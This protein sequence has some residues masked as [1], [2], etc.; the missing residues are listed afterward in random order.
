MGAFMIHHSEEMMVSQHLGR[1][2]W[3]RMRE[4]VLGQRESAVLLLSPALPPNPLETTGPESVTPWSPSSHP[5]GLPRVTAA[6]RTGWGDSSPVILKMDSDDG[7]HHGECAG[8]PCQGQRR[9]KE[10]RVW[11][12]EGEI[13]E[14]EPGREKGAFPTWPRMVAYIGSSV[15]KDAS[16][17]G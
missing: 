9:E 4:I 3:G 6:R 15:R 1:V 16:L 12:E 5:G 8:H 13:K 10:E 17:R 2:W 7:P 11:Q 14:E